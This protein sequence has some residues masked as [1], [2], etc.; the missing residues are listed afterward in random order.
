MIGAEQAE[1]VLLQYRHISTALLSLSLSF[2][3]SLALSLRKAHCTC[4]WAERRALQR[5]RGLLSLSPRL[6]AQ[7][8]AECLENRFYPV[9][10]L[11]KAFY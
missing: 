4:R 3:L 8:S 11:K 6:S 7:V 2:S 1:M 5:K 10:H 9:F